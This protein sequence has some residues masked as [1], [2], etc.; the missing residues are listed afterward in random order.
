MWISVGGVDVS[1]WCDRVHVGGVTGY[2]Y[3]IRMCG[4]PVSGMLPFFFFF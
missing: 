4:I 1:W 3:E 2:E